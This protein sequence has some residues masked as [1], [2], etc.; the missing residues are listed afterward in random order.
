MFQIKIILS[1]RICDKIVN[2][3]KKDITELNHLLKH[4]VRQTVKEVISNEI[5]IILAKTETIYGNVSEQVLSA[6]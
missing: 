2:E 1:K 4:A 5:N 3:L 6:P